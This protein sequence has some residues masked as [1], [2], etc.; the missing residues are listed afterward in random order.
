MNDVDGCGT[1]CL[2]LSH[3]GLQ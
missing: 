2:T 1:L 3:S